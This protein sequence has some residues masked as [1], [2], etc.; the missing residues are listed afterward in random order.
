MATA[1]TKRMRKK[2]RM[3]QARMKPRMSLRGEMPRRGKRVESGGGGGKEDGVE[4][5]TGRA[6]MKMAGRVL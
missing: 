6:M 3:E 2:K 1:V 4:G 5:I